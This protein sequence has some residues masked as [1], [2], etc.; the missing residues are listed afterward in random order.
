MAI[1]VGIVF[2]IT[3]I[4]APKRGLIRFFFIKKKQ[5]KEFA[6]LTL[7]IHLHM[8]QGKENAYKENGYKTICEHIRW[9]RKKLDKMLK[10]LIKEGKIVLENGI[11]I[12]TSEGIKTTEAAVDSLLKIE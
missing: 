10:D 2:L 7:M 11:L 1:V 12:L 4:F 9:E 5:R 8:H 6:I 3:F